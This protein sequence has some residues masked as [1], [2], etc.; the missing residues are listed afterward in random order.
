MNANSIGAPV[1]ATPAVTAI[2]LSD[3]HTP[4]AG[5]PVAIRTGLPSEAE[6][7]TIRPGSAT[8]SRRALLIG[9]AML[10]LSACPAPAPAAPSASD[11]TWDRL[12]AAYELA[13]VEHVARMSAFNE[14]ERAWAAA[15][16][17]AEPK[18]I[19]PFLT[20]DAASLLT[21][22]IVARVKAPEWV[23]RCNAYDAEL[24]A[25]TAR[26]REAEERFMGAE[27]DAMI[28]AE[29]VA[30]DAFVAIRSYRVPSYAAL[31]AKAEYMA[32]RYGDDLEASEALALIA[33]IRHLAGKEA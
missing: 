18:P 23:A 17:F 33:D 32:E 8:P 26:R 10:P 12:I 24:A 29:R 4:R 22:E 31:T 1:S 27:E 13:G 7:K 2:N 30:S 21:A 6:R 11:P 25:W 16:G 14:R 3:D 19:E 9:A 28:A 15:G 5:T 20:A